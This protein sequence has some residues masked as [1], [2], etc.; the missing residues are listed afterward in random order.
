[1]Q[2]CNN[3]SRFNYK[4]KMRNA[5]TIAKINYIAKKKLISVYVTTGN[6]KKKKKVNRKGRILYSYTIHKSFQSHF[7][8]TIKIA[9]LCSK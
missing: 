8:K 9:N 5:L 3:N 2:M 4:I 1:M 7:F 6:V